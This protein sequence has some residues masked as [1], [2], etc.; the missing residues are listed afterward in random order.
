MAAV[1]GDDV[2]L[3]ALIVDL[4]FPFCA[5]SRYMYGISDY[6]LEISL[7]KAYY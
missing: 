5:L 7:G 4:E 3:S 1:D 2:M 6:S